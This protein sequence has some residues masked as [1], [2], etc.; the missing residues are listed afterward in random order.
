MR[1]RVSRNELVKHI[2]D[3]MPV[4]YNEYE[5]L[6]FIELEVAKK[7]A[8]DEQYLWGDT[9]TKQKIYRAAKKSARNPRSK[10]D[11]KLICVTMSELFGYIA[12][13]VGFNVKFQIR[14]EEETKTGDNEILKNISYK[15][16]EHVCCIVELF[17]GKKIEVDIQEDLYRLQTRC[18]PNAFGQVIHQGGIQVLPPYIINQAF[19]KVYHLKENESFMDKHIRDL[20]I[21]LQH[22]N[23]TLVEMLEAFMKD[24]RIQKQLKDVGCVEANKLFK[25]ILG[26][27]CGFGVD[28]GFSGKDGKAFMDECILSDNKGKKKYSFCLYAE[29]DTRKVLYVYS[30]K[31]KRMVTVTPEDIKRMKQE[32]MNLNLRAVYSPLKQSMLSYIN[33]EERKADSG[34]EKASTISVEDIFLDDEEK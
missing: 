32:P 11:K 25:K 19:K 3:T 12:K 20:A 4:D 15:K 27:I 1:K 23:K 16:Q 21:R 2:L 5:K 29:D 30:K 24:S 8:F 10:T 34:E 26:T 9:E 33:S 18:R 13:A 6:A 14:G 31:S 28:C 17:D 22:G 7:I